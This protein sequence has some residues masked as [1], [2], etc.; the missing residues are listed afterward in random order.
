MGQLKTTGEI[1]TNQAP[2]IT[3]QN[4]SM[5]YLS[6]LANAYDGDEST[7]AT[8]QLKYTGKPVTIRHMCPAT[9]AGMGIPSQAKI[10]SVRVRIKRIKQSGSAQVSR[11]LRVYMNTSADGTVSM[12]TR[13]D[14]LKGATN[15]D[16][17]VTISSLDVYAW[18]PLF[19]IEEVYTLIASATNYIYIYETFWEITYEEGG[20]IKVGSAS[21][22]KM[23][24]GTNEVD[25]STAGEL[26]LK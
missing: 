12:Y 26:L 25:K 1:N 11:T 16:V 4:T 14:D 5:Y 24:V 13:N 17:D 21:V 15:A 23:Y 18:Q 8:M 10:R 9:L 6:G 2:T 22:T 19:Y 20:D 7:K 3:A